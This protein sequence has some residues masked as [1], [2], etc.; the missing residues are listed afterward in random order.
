MQVPTSPTLQRVQTGLGNGI[1][2][3][4]LST[5]G[6]GVAVACPH[7]QL[8]H[9]NSCFVHPRIGQPTSSF[10]PFRTMSQ[11]P[12]PFALS[13]FSQIDRQLYFDFSKPTLSSIHFHCDD[14]FLRRLI[15]A[16][17]SNFSRN[18]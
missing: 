17:D 11:P 5:V 1:A 6:P 4:P 2:R 14:I 3:T 8:R 18:Y 16:Q 15:G 9:F 13:R 7:G 10:R 12:S